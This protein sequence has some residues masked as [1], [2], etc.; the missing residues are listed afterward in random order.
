MI[1][2]LLLCSNSISQC[3]IL[4]SPNY[5]FK[6][7]FIQQI[8]CYYLWQ[9]VSFYS[10]DR[11]HV[12]WASFKHEM[13]FWIF[14]VKISVSL[15]NSA[16]KITAWATKV[17]YQAGV[18]TF[19][20]LGPSCWMLTVGSIPG[21]KVTAIWGWLLDSCF[22]A[23]TSSANHHS[24]VKYRENLLLPSWWE[25]LSRWNLSCVE[26]VRT[27]TLF[28]AF[29]E[30]LLSSRLFTGMTQISE[31]KFS[32]FPF[33]NVSSLYVQLSN[34]SA[35]RRTPEDSYVTNMQY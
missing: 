27:S 5:T 25:L 20:F 10:H 32:L 17:R 13:L 18:G 2:I 21:Y 9:P 28:E 29:N 8:C 11:M 26:Q 33:L 34:Q 7:Y 22:Q 14:I 23:S 6:I 12:Q 4:Y 24:E 15:D 19:L 31:A 16:S 30:L 1:T 35:L 3:I